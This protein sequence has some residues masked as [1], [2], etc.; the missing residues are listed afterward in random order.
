MSNFIK[1]CRDILLA[2]FVN[3]LLQKLNVILG[4]ISPEGS[5]VPKDSPHCKYTRDLEITVE[6][7]KA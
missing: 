6:W 5:K 1:D 7:N 4:A 3:L 2:V